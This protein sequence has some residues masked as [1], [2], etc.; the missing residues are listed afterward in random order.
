MFTCWR[1][2]PSRI[3]CTIESR[4]KLIRLLDRWIFYLFDIRTA[5]KLESYSMREISCLNCTTRPR[6]YKNLYLC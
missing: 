6:L 3:D 5:G 1:D 4:L 2:I